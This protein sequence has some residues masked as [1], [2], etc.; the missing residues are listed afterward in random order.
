MSAEDHY[1]DAIEA[2]DNGNREEALKQ[3]YKAVKLDPEHTDAW[4]VISDS[5]LN[6]KGQADNLIDASKS[7]SA[8]K[9]IVNLDPSRIDMWVRGGRLLADELGLMIDALEWWQEVRHHAPYEVTP[10]IEQATIMADLGLYQEGRERIETILNENMDVATSQYGRVHQLLGLFNSAIQQDQSQYFKPWEK[11]HPGWSAIESKMRKPPV[12]ET[13]IF[14]L[15]TV[16]I[17]FGVVI[18]SNML[19]GEGF[20]AFCLTSIVIFVAVI[21][22]MRFTKN[23]FRSINRPAFN[24]LRAMNF[25]SSTGYSIISEEIKTSVLYMYILQRKPIAW[26]ERMLLIVEE[27]TSL[28]KN[29]KL[30]LPDFD[31]HLDEIGYIEDG[32]EQSPFWETGDGAEPHEEE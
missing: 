15:V 9:K 3:A 25:E 16:P 6:S 8:V 28:P 17:L 23:M 20:T 21:A 14:M 13:F 7:L 27:N 1:L 5:H 11:R 30:E 12:S 4:Q 31:S 24:L 18:L 22:G 26:Q 10:L 2:L 19:A 32:D 29:W